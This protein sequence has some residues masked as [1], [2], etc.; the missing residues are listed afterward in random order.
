MSGAQSEDGS[1]QTSQEGKELDPRD[2]EAHR[3]VGFDDPESQEIF[4][5]TQSTAAFPKRKAAALLLFMKVG[6]LTPTRDF[7]GGEP[8]G[9]APDKSK[10]NSK[11]R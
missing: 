1:V 7:S 5:L 9:S 6:R 10:G 3:C 4:N 2:S 11:S 8:R